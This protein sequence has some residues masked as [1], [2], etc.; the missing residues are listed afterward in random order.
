[1]L[2]ENFIFGEHFCITKMDDVFGM[3]KPTDSPVNNQPDISKQKR[4]TAKIPVRARNASEV[5]GIFKVSKTQ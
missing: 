4:K 3:P 1:M 2:P 5:R